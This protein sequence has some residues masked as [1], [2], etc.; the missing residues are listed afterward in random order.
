MKGN[1][2]IFIV[3]EGGEGSG[4][5]T[6]AK[7]L[8]EELVSKGWPMFLTKEPG[9]DDGV[10]KDIRTV[11]LNPKYKGSMDPKTELMLF[12]ADRAQHVGQVLEPE[13]KNG[14]LVICDR[15]EGSTFAYQCAA[16]GF[17]IQAFEMLNQ[18]ATGGLKPNFIFWL[19]IDPEIGL[20]R[21]VEVSKRDRFEMEDVSFHKNVR[22]GYEEYFKNMEPRK[23]LK[24]DASRPIDELHKEIVLKVVYMIRSGLY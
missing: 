6:Q 13:I 12:A 10:C 23:Y 16:R 17:S 22:V 11:L 24:L 19:D 18:Y 4:K 3:F 5:S 9:G 15:Y 1:R 20:K 7:L 2:G 14:K 8:Y 21:N